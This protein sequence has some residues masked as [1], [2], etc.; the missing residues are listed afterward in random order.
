M[1]NSVKRQAIMLL[2]LVVALPLTVAQFV[3]KMEYRRALGE[4]IID[5]DS[6]LIKAGL[7]EREVEGWQA[8]F[9]IAMEESDVRRSLDER[10]ITALRNENR[11]LRESGSATITVSDTVFVE[12][13]ATDS[14]TGTVQF[15]GESRGLVF[16]AWVDKALSQLRLEWQL[17]LKV[18][19]IVADRPD[20]GRD[21]Y[22]RAPD[23]PD[24]DVSI[25][26]FDYVP[27]TEKWYERIAFGPYASAGTSGVHFGPTGCYGSVCGG[28][29]LMGGEIMAA[30]YWRPFKKGN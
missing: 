28:F 17:S 22:V 8:R 30:Y 2:L 23:Y 4:A 5:R 26:R 7:A 12:A 20:G 9:G 1:T 14:T 27:R 3:E 19:I 11:R 29:D 16:T 21:V 13:G 6:A 10:T 25:G 15:S 24:A 18:D